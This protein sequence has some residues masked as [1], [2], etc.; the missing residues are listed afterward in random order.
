VSALPLHLVA[1]EDPTTALLLRLAADLTPAQFCELIAQRFHLGPGS[2]EQTIELRFEHG[3]FRWAKL[4]SGRIGLDD[5]D[6]VRR[7]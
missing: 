5:I 6:T 3:S 7:P 4:H 1:G 2:G